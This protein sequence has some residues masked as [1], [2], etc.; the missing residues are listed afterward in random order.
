M[1]GEVIHETVEKSI[2]KYTTLTCD[3]SEC[4]H[5]FRLQTEIAQGIEHTDD[6]VR[7][8]AAEMG[9]IRLSGRFDLCPACMSSWTTE[10][11]DDPRLCSAKERPPLHKVHGPHGF[12]WSHRFTGP[13]KTTGGEDAD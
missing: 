9:W 12:G 10:G 3:N 1:V 8:E 6:V 4:G 13:T 11:A 2:A 7:A 5:G